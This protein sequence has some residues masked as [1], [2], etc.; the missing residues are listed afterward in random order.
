MSSTDDSQQ[1][2][3]NDDALRAIDGAELL[4]ALREVRGISQDGWAALLGVGRATVQRWERGEAVPDLAAEQ[5]LVALCHEQALFRGL[6]LE[7]LHGLTLTPELLRDLLASARLQRPKPPGVRSGSPLPHGSAAAT[8]EITPLPVPVSSMLWSGPTL[9]TGTLTFLFSD[10]EGSTRR[11]EEHEQEM[12]ALIARH[13]A[14]LGGIVAAHDGVVVRPRGEGDSLF[15]VFVRASDAAGA[16]LAGQRALEAEDWGAVGP[17]RVRMGLHTGEADLRDGDYYGS[18]VNRCARIRATGHGGQIIV[19]AAAAQLM[20]YELPH[21]AGLRDLGRHRLKDLT[22][23]EQLYQLEAPGL[24]RSFPPL[25]TLGYRPNNLPLAQTDFLGRERE[26]AQALRLLRAERLAT[27]TGPGGTGKTRLALQVAAEALDDFADG[28]FFVDLAPISDPALVAAVIAQ[29]LGVREAPGQTQ[30]DALRSYL[31]DRNLLLLLDNFEQVLNAAPLLTVLL[32]NCPS[33]KLLVTS[34]TVLRL[35]GEHEL[36]VAPLPLPDAAHRTDPAALQQYTAV[37]LFVARAQNARPGFALT[38]EN[39]EAV[40]AICARL[41]GLP[42][43]IELAAARIRVLLPQ[44]LLERLGAR[45]KLLTG[46]ARDAP[47]RQRTL[48]D[49]IAWSYELLEPEERTLFCWLAPFAAGCTLESIEAICTAEAGPRIDPLDGIESLVEKSLLRLDDAETGEPR[50][51]MLATIREFALEQLA[52]GGADGPAWSAFLAH[53]IALAE[54]AETALAGADQ[55]AWLGR[56]EQEHDN[57]RVALD[58]AIAMLAAGDALRLAGALWRFWDLRGYL[59][60]GRGWLERALSAGAGLDA[61]ERGKVLNGAGWLA[62]RQ[63]DLAR[64]A[65]LHEENLDLARRLHDQRRTVSALIN[66]A[67]VLRE[68]TEYERAHTLYDE[69]LAIN[70]ALGERRGVAL[71]GAH[72]GLVAYYTGDFGAAH[73]HYSDALALLREAGDRANAAHTLANLGAVADRLGELDRAVA[74]YEQALAEHRE[75]NATYGAM[76]ALTCLGRLARQ[77]G[78][79]PRAQTLCAEAGALCRELGDRQWL[80]SLLEELAQLAAACGD[81]ERAA[82]LLGAAAGLREALGAPAPP[83]VVPELTALAAHLRTALG[84]TAFERASRAG[85]ATPAETLLLPTSPAILSA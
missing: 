80:I 13:D 1:P 6:E 16:A 64:A 31:T 21:D 59:S 37:A 40:A 30:Q 57:L 84:G 28:V 83:I 43:A 4:R 47:A 26:V 20:R 55:G 44:A 46:G 56:L 18:A 85:R 79:L 36:P 54:Q 19:S 34:R 8:G 9:P 70:Q 29:T 81:P 51:S 77:Q 78:D 32:M 66:L 14:L 72:L 11:W 53:C 45:L 60:E 62:M 27:L 5:A 82:R 69:A 42:L 17:L 71:V 22:E 52:A 38:E 76:I 50:F 65:T 73:A 10:V 2:A 63:G 49:T 67:I 7:L 68:R 58:H 24:P 41:D 35:V 48:R 61:P 33:I 25:K 39:A 15:C 75:L 74:L 23:P 3:L 12:R